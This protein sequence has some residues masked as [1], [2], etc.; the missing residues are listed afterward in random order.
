MRILNFALRHARFTR[1]L[2]CQNYGYQR[3]EFALILMTVDD[4]R[5]SFQLKG[6]QI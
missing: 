4:F 2:R 3:M 6:L 5:M 1:L